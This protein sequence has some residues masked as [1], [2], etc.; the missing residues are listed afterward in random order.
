M[1]KKTHEHTELMLV[2]T[3]NHPFIDDVINQV[4]IGR[5]AVYRHFRQIASGSS[6]MGPLMEFSLR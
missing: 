3:E 1:R 6:E 5:T 4:R 2:G